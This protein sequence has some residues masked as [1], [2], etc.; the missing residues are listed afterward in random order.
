MQRSQRYGILILA[1]LTVA[2]IVWIM[3]F[4]H[5]ETYRGVDST[6]FVVLHVGEPRTQKGDTTNVKSSKANKKAKKSGKSADKQEGKRANE[7]PSRSDWLEE[8]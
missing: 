3:F 2:S 6:E 7:A 5:R 1:V 4:A 8:P